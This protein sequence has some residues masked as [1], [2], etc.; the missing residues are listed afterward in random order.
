LASISMPPDSTTI[1]LLGKVKKRGRT[2]TS[3]QSEE[4]LRIVSRSLETKMNGLPYCLRRNRKTK[5]GGYCLLA[6]S[7]G[8]MMTLVDKNEFSMTHNSIIVLFV[9]FVFL[10]HLPFCFLCLYYSVTSALFLLFIVIHP[11]GDVYF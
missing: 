7:F 10:S 1:P 9:V 4:L 3:D 8:F 11:H 5:T 2:T 6:V